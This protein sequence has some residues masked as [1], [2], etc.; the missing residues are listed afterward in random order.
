MPHIKILFFTIKWNSWLLVVR[1]VFCFV[2]TYF[3]TSSFFFLHHISKLRYYQIFF[4]LVSCHFFFFFNQYF[5]LQKSFFY[6]SCLK[7]SQITSIMFK[8]LFFFGWYLIFSFL[9][10]K[11]KRFFFCSSNCGCDYFLILF[12]VGK[13]TF[14][15][16]KAETIHPFLQ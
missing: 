5:I 11:G 13:N 3:F 2:F 16:F 8:N 15:S 14:F 12:W 9:R 4:F 7:R 6:F 1:S 10:R